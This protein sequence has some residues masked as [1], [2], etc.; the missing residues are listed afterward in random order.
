MNRGLHTAYNLY[1]LLVFM[2]TVTFFPNFLPKLSSSTPAE[3]VETVS[4]I[5]FNDFLHMC[6]QWIPVLSQDFFSQKP[7]LLDANLILLIYGTPV[8]LYLLSSAPDIDCYSMMSEVTFLPHSIFYRILKH[9]MPE[10]MGHRGFAHSIF[11]AVAVTMLNAVA[12]FYLM[13]AAIIFFPYYARSIL[14]A[15][16]VHQTYF[17]LCYFG[18]LILDTATDSGVR[19]LYPAETVF[20]S[21]IS[22]TFLPWILPPAYFMLTPFLPP[23]MRVDVWGTL[24]KT[25]LYA[26]VLSAAM[27]PVSLAVFTVKENLGRN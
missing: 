26:F 19:L 6:V 22:V 17:T 7:L 20:R 5:K 10:H 12:D 13:K 1:L 2:F 25:I 15:A 18:H 11:Y 24:F 8:L 9:V 23:E 16:I 4:A 21:R 14:L 3:I 27:V